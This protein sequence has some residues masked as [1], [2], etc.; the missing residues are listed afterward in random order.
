MPRLLAV[1]VGLCAFNH[2]LWPAWDWWTAEPGADGFALEPGL[3]LL[4]D[5][6]ASLPALIELAL[7]WCIARRA[8]WAR[9][10]FVAWTAFWSAAFLLLACYVFFT[11]IPSPLPWFEEPGLVVLSAWSGAVSLATAALLL[12]RRWKGWFRNEGHGTAGALGA[13]P[14]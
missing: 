7:L 2:G 8:D 14:C 4:I 11:G 12:D 1:L 5:A 3:A 10:A 13:Q 6:A 9:K